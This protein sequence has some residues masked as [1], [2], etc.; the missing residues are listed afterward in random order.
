MNR[1]RCLSCGDQL[2]MSSRSDRLTCS[3]LCRKRLSLARRAE[4]AA[5]AAARARQG[6]TTPWKGHRAA[7]GPRCER[8]GLQ[9]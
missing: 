6:A 2:G 9:P 8:R 7:S 1:G 4:D 3:D 5:S